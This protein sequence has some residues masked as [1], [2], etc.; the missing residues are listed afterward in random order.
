[1]LSL[2]FIHFLAFTAYGEFSVINQAITDPMVFAQ[3][4]SSAS[5][6]QINNVIDIINGLIDDGKAKNKSIVDAYNAALTAQ[7]TAQ[8]NER[9]ALKA[10]EKARGERKVMSG[11]VN[12][13]KLVLAAN[14]QA[15]KSALTARDLATQ[16]KDE[17]QAWMEKEEK[18]IN[19]EKNILEG[20]I[21]TLNQLP[22]SLIGSERNLLSLQSHLAP[23]MP[24]LIAAAKVN[25]KTLAKV[26]EMVQA[27]IDAGETIRK[28][29]ISDRDQAEQN[30]LN[31]NK[32]YLAAVKKTLDTQKK[33]DS[34]TQKL[35]DLVDVEEKAE[36]AWKDTVSKLKTANGI[37]AT[38]KQEMDTQ[39]PILNK[40]D[41]QLK[42]VVRILT[43]MLPKE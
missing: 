6:Q 22:R 33:L 32:A 35:N 23:I 34:E 27:L 31:K 37:L 20:V 43:G 14:E 30:R 16:K 26:V 2:L 40:E 11:V 13:T 21:V 10:F 29:V 24:A 28:K 36:S 5:P 25:P 3:S 17:A 38:K 7:G 41:G 18:R 9:D 8:Q 15:Q 12:K 19:K 39:V 4:F 1:M 42:E